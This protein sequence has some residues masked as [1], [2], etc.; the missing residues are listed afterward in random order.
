[1]WGS[2]TG[3][4]FEL[5][6]KVLIPGLSQSVVGPQLSVTNVTQENKKCVSLL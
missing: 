1:M 4:L 5:L 6:S 2:E 3:H